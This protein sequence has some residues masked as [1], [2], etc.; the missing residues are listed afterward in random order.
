M[1]TG[2][3]ILNIIKWLDENVERVLLVIFLTVI[4]GAMLIQI[5][6]R[7][8]F[9][10]SLAWP[11]EL[12]RYCFIWF[13][14]IAYSYSIKL[15]MEL[16]VDSVVNMLPEKAKNFVTTLTTFIGLVFTFFLFVNSFTTVS[17][18]YISGDYSIAMKI[19]MY[20]VFAS[21]VFGFGFATIRYIQNFVHIFKREG[22]KI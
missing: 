8:V 11:E 2:G 16:R 12:C 15:K 21:T 9:N 22:G 19:P 3:V 13:M 18:V 6:M 17:N 10:N 7:Y 4:L 20:F 1:D 5:V 14:F